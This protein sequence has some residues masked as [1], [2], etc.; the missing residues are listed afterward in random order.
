MY[1]EVCFPFFI[2]K[3]FSY[4]V[5]V[6]LQPKIRVGYFVQV[7]FRSKVTTG[8][9]ASLS[10]KTSFKGNLNHI[11]SIDSKNILP[12]ELWETLQWMENYYI[13]PIGKIMQVTLSWVF[14]KNIKNPKKIKHI[15]LSKEARNNNRLFHDLTKNQKI[16]IEYLLKKE[17][18]FIALSDLNK[19]E[20]S[21]NVK[22]HFTE[23]KKQI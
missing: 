11:I 6:E 18:T 20:K 21:S 15:K 3:T 1:A 5:P 7:K 9:I 22:E 14:K 12:E 16:F 17:S 13:T 8:L 23:Y 19:F 4:Y 2:N 10:S